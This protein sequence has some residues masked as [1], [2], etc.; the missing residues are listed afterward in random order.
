MHA[1]DVLAKALG[2]VGGRAV[3]PGGDLARIA[4]LE[5]S[6][7]VGRD[8]QGDLDL[9][10]FEPELHLIGSLARRVGDEVPGALEGRE[11]GAALGRAIEVEVGE[12][13]VLDVGGDAEAEG[14]HHEGGADEGEQEA[15]RVALDLLGLASA[16][17]EHP[18][19]AEPGPEHRGRARGP[20][21]RRAVARAAASAARPCSSIPARGGWRR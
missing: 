9:M 20:P 21:G 3:D 11:V 16:V 2:A 8:L 13:D 7:E 10:R 5:V 12:A 4:L 17:G 15:D 14:E 1:H 6:A 18:S 19:Q